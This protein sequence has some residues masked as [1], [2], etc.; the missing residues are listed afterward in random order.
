[1][2]YVRLAPWKQFPSRAQRSATLDENGL[3]IISGGT[4][5]G[6]Y[7]IRGLSMFKG[8]RYN[9]DKDISIVSIVKDQTSAK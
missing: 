2:F 5:G 6:T 1:M 9:T 8:R 3:Q 4:S 7:I